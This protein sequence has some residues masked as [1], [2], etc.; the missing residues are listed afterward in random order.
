MSIGLCT[1]DHEINSS[2]VLSG[3]PKQLGAVT[4]SENAKS[5]GYNVSF[6]EFLFNQ[7][8]YKPNS[9]TGQYNPRFIVQLTDNYRSHKDILQTSNK[10]Y[11]NNTLQCKASTGLF[12]ERKPITIE[13]NE[14]DLYR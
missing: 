6:M 14:T 12:Y 9:E 5:L 4:K 2:I 7:K 1:D 10:L 13:L 8:A 11:Y 3:D